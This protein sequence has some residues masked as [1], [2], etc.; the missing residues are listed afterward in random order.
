MQDNHS[1]NNKR[2]AKNT[3]VLYIRMIFLL[4][5]SLYT[6]RIIL[7]G[8]GVEN[9]GIYNVVGG[10]IAMFSIISNTLSASISR[11]ITYELGCEKN[12]KLQLIFATSVNIQLIIVFFIILLGETIGLWFINNQLNIPL[13]KLHEANIVYHCS[14]I[15]FI[16]NLVSVPYNACIIANERMKA[17]AY[18]SIIDAIIKLAIAF[19]ISTTHTNKLTFYG[20][21]M[22]VDAFFIRMIYSLY[23]S[24]HFSYCKYKFIFDRTLFK[25][26]LSFA[27]WNFIGASSGVLKDQG[28]NILINIFFNPSVN[29]ARGIAMQVNAAVQQ[30]SSNFLSAIN[31]Q[32]TKQY[33]AKNYGYC[34]E[35]VNKGAKYSIYLLL[36]I[37][38]PILIETEYIVK[39]WL[40]V[41]PEYTIIFIRLIIIN[42]MVDA[43]SNTIVT[44]MLATGK[45][46]NYQIVVGGCL[47]M[48]LPIAYVLLTFEYPPQI[49]II[50]S[51][52]IAII[53]LFLRLIMIKKVFPYF[54]IVSFIKNVILNATLVISISIIIPFL[55]IHCYTE[56]NMVRFI[57]TSIISI[58]STTTIIF[59][60]GCNNREK[61]YIKNI[62][63]T[64]ILKK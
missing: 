2:I 25:Q 13:E 18:I 45:I 30:F 29:A 3:L 60:T 43:L 33:A 44:L 5:I 16:I 63:Y 15:T 40:G 39:L 42:S 58:I 7:N 64:R 59:F 22:L 52:I 4:G 61:E 35:L 32:I 51:I 31:P 1:Q 38:L 10:F 54:R 27:G 56:A 26:I 6:S 17:F 47:L 19:F 8:L 11:F 37:A 48:N 53:S 41:I 36:I 24:K 50:S 55:F 14:L 9:Y 34:M 28:T 20:V 23:C 49:T 57:L 21:L 12:N 62:I 46:K